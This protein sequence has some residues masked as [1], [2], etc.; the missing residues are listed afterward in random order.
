MRDAHRGIRRID[1]LA[2]GARRAIG[3]DAAIGFLHVDVDLVVDDGI[4]PDRGKARVPARIGIEGRDSHQA[5]DAR[6]R[7]GPAMRIV[8]LYEQRGGFD[9]R[10][11]A[12]RFFDDLDLEL[13]PLSPARVH[14]EQHPR[15][16]AAFRAAGA[17]M[18][19]DIGVVLVDLAGKQRLDLPALDVPASALELGNAFLLGF[20]IVLGLGQFNKRHRVIEIGVE[21]RDGAKPVLKLGALAHDFL[22]GFGVVPE[23]R[24]STLAFSSASRRCGGHQRQRCLLSNPMDC[25]I[26]LSER[27][28]F[29]THYTEI[30]HGMAA[31]QPVT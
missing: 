9:A 2:A 28:G 27:F 4:D 3:V 21:L 10:L 7:F 15:P 13:M 16:V 12:G 5:V 30:P 19:F 8:A 22:R 14:T 11:V 24:I 18:D 25:L 17:G 26:D 29:G 20:G 31:I 1:V 6:F 23:I